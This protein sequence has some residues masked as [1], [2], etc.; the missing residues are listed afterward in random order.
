MQLTIYLQKVC[1][2]N[3]LIHIN[4]DDIQW[5]TFFALSNCRKSCKNESVKKRVFVTKKVSHEFQLE[6][7]DFRLNSGY[8]EFCFLKPYEI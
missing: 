3:Q 7:T 8:V 2:R 4:I 6:F 5:R 1:L